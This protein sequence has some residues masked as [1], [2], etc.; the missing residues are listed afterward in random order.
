[1][2][3]STHPSAIKISSASAAPA[4]QQTM[5]PAFLIKLLGKIP[6][7]GGDKINPED[8][9]CIEFVTRLQRWTFND[10]LDGVWFH[11]VNEFAGDKKP[12]WAA[13]RIAL[14]RINGVSD[15]VFLC[16]LKSLALEF[17]KPGGKQSEYQ[18]AFE[19]WCKARGVPYHV[20][21]SAD[22][23]QAVLVQYG[24]LRL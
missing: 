2:E 19:Q 18:K 9:I 23:G 7:V 6:R 20:V 15:Y 11:V 24:I 14:G 13:I 10:Q 4:G 12:V 3:Q 16:P 17:K 5:I 21:Y 22:E 1:V 8:K